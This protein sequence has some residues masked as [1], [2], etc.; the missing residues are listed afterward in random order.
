MNLGPSKRNSASIRYR[1]ANGNRIPEKGESGSVSRRRIVLKSAGDIKIAATSFHGQESAVAD[2]ALTNE[3]KPKF[4]NNMKTPTAIAASFF[5]A[6]F[7]ICA[8]LTSCTGAAPLKCNFRSC[9]ISTTDD[10]HVSLAGFAARTKLSD[11]IHIKLRTHCLAISDGAQKVCII[12]ND[13]MEI[14][15]AISDSLRRCISE[16]TGLEMDRILMHNIHT[17][18]APRTGGSCSE[19]GGS[20]YTYRTRVLGA[21]MDNAVETILAEDD[22]VPF[23]LETAK[24]E[25]WINM[26]RCEAEGPVDRDLY[27]ARLVGKDGKPICAFINFACH[28]VSMGPGS[29]LLSSDYSGVARNAIKEKWG[30]EVFQ[31]SGAQGNMDPVGGCQKVGHALRIGYQ[32]AECLERLEFRK[33]GSDNVLKFA[34]GKA[35][36]PYLIDEIT[37]E[38]VKAHADELVSKSTEFPRFADDVRGWEAEILKRFEN[39]PVANKLTFN[40]EAL[41]IDG[42]ILFFSQ[43]E[44]FCEYQTAARKAFPGQTVFFAGYTNGQNSYLP[45]EHAYEVRKGYEYEIEQ[46]HVYIKAPYPLSP[47]MPAAYAKAVNETIEK[48]I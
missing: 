34:T 16:R 12:S 19:P 3:T 1:I 24:G 7:T 45:S 23:E 44:P 36:L 17:H 43:G 39:G 21:I 4:L 8:A 13:L 11:G 41:N 30:C 29:Y 15:P 14:S 6:A 2:V 33:A 5:I 40:M 10:E 48:V 27:A 35:E 28:P 22:Y 46:M 26:N 37:P 38:A 47:E 9:D 25:A 31:L 20:N 42:V 18:S 32:L